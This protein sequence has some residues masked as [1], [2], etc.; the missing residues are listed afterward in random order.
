[1]TCAIS[2]ETRFGHDLTRE[3]AWFKTKASGHLSLFTH[4]LARRFG[5]DCLPHFTR[6]GASPH[7]DVKPMAYSP[8][9]FGG[10]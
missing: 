4:S 5:H 2:A 7:P 10:I 9:D 3:I 6:F 8:I 1:M